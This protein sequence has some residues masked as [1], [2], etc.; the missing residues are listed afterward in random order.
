MTMPTNSEGHAPAKA[1]IEKRYANSLDVRVRWLEAAS[2]SAL[3]SCEGIETTLM[4]NV[5]VRSL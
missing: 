5:L 1:Y 2:V 4:V 3:A